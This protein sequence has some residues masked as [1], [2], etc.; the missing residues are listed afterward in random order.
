M[1]N[2]RGSLHFNLIYFFVCSYYYYMLNYSYYKNNIA[3]AIYNFDLTL[4]IPKPKVFVIIILFLNVQCY[5]YYHHHDESQKIIN[6]YNKIY[7]YGTYHILDNLLI[8]LTIF[9][10]FY[11]WT[12]VCSVAA[13]ISFSMP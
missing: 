11:L 5:W 10:I 13:S 1:Q 2:D 4:L 9:P 6:I 7:I 3:N 8:T 12:V